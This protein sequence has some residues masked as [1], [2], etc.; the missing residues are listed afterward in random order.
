MNGS[1][2]THHNG[3]TS[4]AL[5]LLTAGVSVLLGQVLGLFILA[6]DGTGFLA[7]RFFSPTLYSAVVV[8]VV[9][10][11]VYLLIVISRRRRGQ[12]MDVSVGKTF[13]W[14]AACALVLNLVPTITMALPELGGM[15][16][17]FAMFMGGLFGT[18]F[19]LPLAVALTAVSIRQY[20]SWLQPSVTQPQIV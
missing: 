7:Q 17:G 15:Y 1:T 20:R 19:T 2:P 12:W 8:F 16:F 14:A 4:F 6:V 5:G 9:A 11:V 10:L 3:S 13:G 18:V